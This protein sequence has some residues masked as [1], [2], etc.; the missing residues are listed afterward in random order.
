M[1]MVLGTGAATSVSTAAA[2]SAV[3]FEDGS[4]NL[5]HRQQLDMTDTNESGDKM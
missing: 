2:T 3:A 5:K 4:L 1:Q